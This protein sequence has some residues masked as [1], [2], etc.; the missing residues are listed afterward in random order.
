MPT[1]ISPKLFGYF[2]LAMNSLQK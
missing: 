2:S 1:V